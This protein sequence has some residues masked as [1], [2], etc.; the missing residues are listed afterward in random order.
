[1]TTKHEWRYIKGW[2]QRFRYCGHCDSRQEHSGAHWKPRPGHPADFLPP[3]RAELRVLRLVKQGGEINDRNE[4]VQSYDAHPFALMDS[5]R[6]LGRTNAQMMEN[7][8]GW[9]GWLDG[10]AELTPEGEVVLRKAKP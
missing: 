5:H 6:L 10:D 1:M 9:R 3:R 4:I 2:G 8:I 7:L